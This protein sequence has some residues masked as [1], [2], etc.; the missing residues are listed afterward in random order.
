MRGVLGIDAATRR[1]GYATG[2]PDRDRPIGGGSWDLPGPDPLVIFSTFTRAYGSIFDLCR[3]VKPEFTIIEAN[4]APMH[5]GS[6]VT[7]ILALAQ[8]VAV[9]V[10][11]A[12]NAG[13]KVELV[14][15]KTI[16][17]FFVGRGNFSKDEDPKLYVQERC[18]KLGWSYKNHDHADALAA[19]AYGLNKHYSWTPEAKPL[20]T[21]TAA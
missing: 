21:R 7:T 3:V 17:K 16:R 19:C 14:S 5:G 9:M 11:A 6:N 4:I 18:D 20:F 10:T 15:S 1:T 2:S 12:T 13:S 8:L